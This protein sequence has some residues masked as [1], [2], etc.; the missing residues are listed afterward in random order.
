MN[1]ILVIAMFA[2]PAALD[3]YNVQFDR[4]RQ[5]LNSGQV[6]AARRDF[7]RLKVL[8]GKDAERI[9]FAQ[10]Q[11]ARCSHKLGDPLK[12]QNELEDLA[13]KYPN[14]GLM[15]R[16]H[17]D[18]G[19]WYQ[20]NWK[21]K[22]ADKHLMRA[23]QL[24]PGYSFGGKN[25]TLDPMTYCR[26][27]LSHAINLVVLGSN[28]QAR[29]NLESVERE[30]STKHGHD[31]EAPYFLTECEIQLAELDF[32]ERDTLKAITRMKACLARV[33]GLGIKLEA[34]EL[35]FA[36][37]CELNYMYRKLTRFA[38]ADKQLTMAEAC[39]TRIADMEAKE[40]NRD[41]FTIRPSV[42]HRAELE[43][44]KGVLLAE[45]VRS[46]FERLGGGDRL[47]TRLTTAQKAADEAAKATKAIGGEETK[48]HAAN[49]SLYGLIE[50]LRG[51]V[52]ASLGR[53][54]AG[55]T[56][57]SARKFYDESIER[58]TALLQDPHHDVP[59]DLRRYRIRVLVSGNDLAF[60]LSEAQAI[61]PHYEGRPELVDC[62][63]LLVDI[64]AKRKEEIDLA[65]EH[66]LRSQRV[67]NEQLLGYVTGLTPT[68][69]QDF[70]RIWI[71]PA[72]HSS[73][74]LAMHVCASDELRDA[75]C[76]WLLNGKVKS[77]EILALIGRQAP[78][79]NRIELLQTVEHL[80]YMHYGGSKG[81]IDEL[82]KIEARRRELSESQTKALQVTW[83][84]MEDL[85]A[86]L[87][88]NEA[89]VDIFALKDANERHHYFAWV[90]T[91]DLP[92]QVVRL[93]D[94]DGD[95]EKINE[96][97]AQLLGYFEA[98]GGNNP[99]NPRDL[100]WVY[101]KDE[102]A[103]EEHLRNQC[104]A[105]LSKLVLDPLVKAAGEKDRWIISPDGALRSLPWAALI[106]PATGG[107]VVRTTTL[108]YAISAR[109]LFTRNVTNPSAPPLVVSHPALDAQPERAVTWRK[110]TGKPDLEMA[111]LAGDE[112][113]EVAT[114]LGTTPLVGKNATKQ[115]ILSQ[116]ATHPSELSP[117]VL[118]LATHGVFYENPDQQVNDPFLRCFV[119]LAGYNIIPAWRPEEPHRLPG[120]LTGSELLF[121]NL[122]GTELVVLSACQ[123]GRGVDSHGHGAAS[124]RHAFH[125]AGAR[126]VVAA[127]WSVEVNATRVLMGDFMR[128]AAWPGSD[129]AKALR[130]AQI[131][132]IEGKERTN[133]FYWAAFSISGF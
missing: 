11:S 99:G 31:R 111:E 35:Q 88:P 1:F 96:L 89:L 106:H 78:S 100:Y 112:G 49:L 71:D 73:L 9:V 68:Q 29:T 7:E 54:G 59:V 103:A 85:R 40:A 36:C 14:S 41:L 53:Q 87:C 30:V 50:A 16:V 27:R 131:S 77:A 74:G 81:D 124:L 3:A 119:A 72:L 2:A 82:L 115:A 120:L 130:S 8:A 83:L 56:F 45:W 48:E 24:G 60:A 18:L 129:K 46:D 105:P 80:A 4:A 34:I 42:R 86:K 113:V 33:Q 12:A 75:T 32:R 79:K 126:A 47:L 28:K 19:Q 23:L 107:Y 118:Y 44:H 57:A 6:E 114:L 133:P 52:L 65:T 101:Q 125:L 95:A 91:T 132:M 104:L 21:A 70:F 43:H 62:H 84:N 22:L 121:A 108:Q 109:D 66:A 25:E 127:N 117:R 94:Q 38:D 17:S 98:Y 110:R 58:Y 128:T 90:L 37:H 92:V 93:G 97:V 67:V 55:L 76:E 51:R 102:A 64:H 26:V 5:N 61:L 63:R 15:L 13:S 10:W 122:R 116:G 20:V 123:V 39:L 69:Q